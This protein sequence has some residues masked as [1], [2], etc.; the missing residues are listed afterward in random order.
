MLNGSC[1]RYLY[2]FKVVLRLKFNRCGF[3]ANVGCDIVGLQVELGNSTITHGREEILKN[4]V[5]L[6]FHIHRYTL[7]FYLTLLFSVIWNSLKHL[8]A[9]KRTYICQEF[10][11]CQRLVQESTTHYTKHC[12]LLRLQVDISTIRRELFSF[13]ALKHDMSCEVIWRG[14]MSNMVE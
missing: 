8:E 3:A 5:A 14:G 12:D 2:N 7:I 4:D 10:L 1:R 11:L 6:Q 13:S 9:M